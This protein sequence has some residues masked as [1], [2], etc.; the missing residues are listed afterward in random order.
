MEVEK[1][2]NI[3]S[4]KKFLEKIEKKGKNIRGITAVPRNL[5][6]FYV[7]FSDEERENMRSKIID[8]RNF[9]VR[10]EM[11]FDT[12]IRSVKKEKLYWQSYSDSTSK[13]VLDYLSW[14]EEQLSF[15]AIAINE[16]M[17]ETKEILMR[18]Y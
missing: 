5:A 3:E 1:V 9:L 18:R 15:S 17:R 2:E 11:A 14:L 12:L 16:M 4:L 7:F 8:F 13:R 10:E 6:S